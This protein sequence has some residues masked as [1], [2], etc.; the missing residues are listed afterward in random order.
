[1]AAASQS[2][3]QPSG[4]VAANYVW[5]EQN[6]GPDQRRR[7]HHQSQGTLTFPIPSSW[8]LALEQPESMPGN[9]LFVDPAYLET[10]GFIPS[11]R[12]PDDNRWGLPIGFARSTGF[13]PRDPRRAYDSIGFTC[14]A[15]HTG[16]IDYQGQSVIIDGAPALINLA[17]FGENLGKSMAETLSPRH[18][19]RFQRFADRLLGP[20]NGVR[21]RLR[22][23]AAMTEVV[24]GQLISKWLSSRPGG[25]EEGY[26]RLDALNRIGN[27]VFALGLDE[28]RNNH[29]LTAPVAFPHI[30]DTHWFDWVQYNSS[31]EQP[32]V[33]NAGEAMGVG[34]IV[35]FREGP[36]PRFTSTVPVDS[37][38][39]SIEG[40]LR[41]ERQPLANREFTGLRSPAW[42]A[43]ILGPVDMQ[44]AQQGRE[45]YRANC[46][47]CHLPA[48]NEEEFWTGNHWTS[49]NAAG[50]RYIALRTIPVDSIGTDPAQA[51]DMAARVIRAPASLG[52]ER[53]IRREGDRLVYG[54]GDAL[55]Q[56]VERSVNVWYDGRTPPLSAADRDRMNGHRPNGIRDRIQGRLVYKARP[57]NGIWATAPF[58]HNGSVRTL[59]QLLSPYAERE[60]AF[61]L[62]SRQFDPRDVGYTNAGPFLLRTVDERGNPVRG[63]ANT[64]HLFDVPTAANRG[65][66]IIGRPL[67]EQ[68]RR[69]IIE[70]LKTI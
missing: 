6:W 17:A 31:I 68:Q 33:R 38:Y 23:R 42:P 24:A 4:A 65:A 60:P 44:L 64:G 40:P 11:P 12:H 5:L 26:G 46:R 54:F 62:G 36:T 16:R 19:D 13:D 45:L 50:E 59:Y 66:G 30:W 52:L 58:L 61:R 1:M 27:R 53:P 39:A 70:F 49:P 14:A 15:C 63:N 10:F 18:L 9:G 67:T 56:V 34:A 7:Y 51:A 43:Q 22:L 47:G 37:L 69:A 28:T 25:V 20:G 41:G 35:N 57:L 55:G 32:M 3:A 21:E 48:P 8:L 2:A 29:A